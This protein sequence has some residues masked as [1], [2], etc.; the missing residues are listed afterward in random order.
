MVHLPD[1]LALE[2]WN[3]PNAARWFAPNPSP[4]LYVRMLRAA[5]Q[6]ARQVGFDRPIIIGGLA[7]KKPLIAGKV[8]PARYL[9]RVY[10]LVGS[11]AF[12]GIGAHPYP[13]GPPWVANTDANLDQL[14]AVSDRFD[15][16]GKPLWI[17]EV[18]LGGTP[19]G[20][21]KFSV[22]LDR[23]GP[24]LTRMYRSI[25]GS[26]VRAFLIYTLYDSTI[27]GNRFG[28][29]GV[30]TPDL[31]PKPAYCYLA[32]HIGRTHACPAAGS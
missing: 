4:A 21:G 19:T 25:Q 20:A 24:I 5:R 7:P 28:P 15:D 16:A 23:Q 3:E 30:L 8:P 10:E 26:N 6:A 31:R 29:Y 2:V 14:H 1:M 9:S 22:P 32:L 13:A 18:G 12:D 27:G 11:Q 17:T